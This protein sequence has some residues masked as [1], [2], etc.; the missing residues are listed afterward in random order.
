MCM[1]SEDAADVLWKFL[2]KDGVYTLRKFYEEEITEE[3]LTPHKRIKRGYY[4]LKEIEPFKFGLWYD[5][6]NEEMLYYL[7]TCGRLDHFYSRHLVRNARYNSKF[8]GNKEI[9]PFGVFSFYCYHTSYSRL[10]PREIRFLDG[11]LRVTSTFYNSFMS[12]LEH[13]GIETFVRGGKG[14]KTFS[15]EL[16]SF[17]PKKIDYCFGFDDLIK[18]DINLFSEKTL[19]N[20]YN[21]LKSKLPLPDSFFDKHLNEQERVS[22]TINYISHQNLRQWNKWKKKQM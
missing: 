10:E 3:E 13:Y 5:G 20:V 21:C 19:N 18:C 9:F 4:Y 7:Y 22:K 17:G 15:L 12:V 14:H 6:L 16:G 2:A 8:V 1:L 11:S